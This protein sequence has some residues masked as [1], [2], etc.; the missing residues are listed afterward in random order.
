LLLTGEQIG[1]FVRDDFTKETKEIIAKRAGYFCSN[2]ECGKPTVGPAIG[3]DKAINEGVAAHITA[4][5][6]GGPRY[7]PSL[8]PTQRKHQSNGIW[9]CS[10]CG[11]RIDADDVHFTVEMLRKW[12]RAAELQALLALAAPRLTPGRRV[13][14]AA[15]DTFEAELE[16]LGLTAQEYFESITLPLISAARTD[17]AAFKNMQ[18]W[19]LHP[20]ALN[21]RI[22]DVGYKQAFNISGLAAAIETFNEIV[23]IAPPGTGKTTTL[24][25]LAE[26]ILSQDKSVAVFIPLSEWS[27]QAGSFLESIVR[28]PA[29]AGVQ[30]EHLVRLAHHGRLVLVLDGWN[31]L[32]AASRK[33][34]TGEIRSLQRDFPD[35]A[36]IVS[37]RR[38]ALDVPISGPVVEIDALTE[39]QQLEIAR[40]LRGTEGEAILDHAWRTPGV[41]DL[42]AIPLYISALLAY[43]K[44][45]SLPTTKEEVLRLFVDEHERKPE[46]AEA[47]RETLLGFHTNM[48]RAIAVKATT[49]ATTTISEKHA[50]AV[51]KQVEDQ[52]LADGQITTAPQPTKVLDALVSH[53]TLVHASAGAGALSFQHQQFQE[54]YA[55]FEVEKLMRSAAAGDQEARQELRANI[56]NIPA[57]EEAILFACERMSRADGTGLK[58]VAAAVLETIGIDPML[59][60]EMIYRSSA[61]VWDEVKGKIIDF[62]EIWHIPGKVDRAFRFMIGTGCGE[63]ASQIWPLISHPDDQVHLE[64]LRAG[65]RFRPSVLGDDIEGHIANLPEEVR[66]NV[67]SSFAYEGDM[68]GIEL[69]AKLAQADPSPEVQVSVI[70]GLWFRRANRLVIEVLRTAPDEVWQLLARKGFADEITDPAA[71]TRLWREWRCYIETQPDS[72]SKLRALLYSGPPRRDLGPEVRTLIEAADFQVRDKHADG[73]IYEAHKRYP[74]DVTSALIHRL[75]AGQE[76][77]F[78]TEDL[79]QA[80][81]IAIDEGPFVD[82]VVH[83]GELEKVA[84]AAVSIAGPKTIGSLIDSLIAIDTKLRASGRQADEPTRQEYYRLRDW[85]SKTNLTSFIQAVLSRSE[86]NDPCQ[87]V[88][89]AKLLTNHG[90]GEFEESIQLDGG[91]EDQM[92]AAISCWAE[93]LLA[94]STASRAHLAEVARAIGRL[95]AP[96]LLPLLQRMLAEDLVRWRRERDEFSAAISRGIHIQSEARS[97]WTLWYRRA[98]SAIGSDAVVGLMKAYLPDTDF[99]FDAACVLKAIWDQKHNPQKDKWPSP[100]PDFSEV[101]ARCLEREEHVSDIHSSPFADAIFAVIDHLT[102]PDSSPNDHLRALQLAKIAFSMP[103]GKKMATIE[104]LLKLP[105][106]RRAKSELLAVLVRSGEII[107]ADMVLDNLKNLIEEG[108]KNPW[109]LDERSREVEDWLVLMPFSDR[110]EATLDALELLGPNLRQPWQMHHLLSALGDSPSPAS[111]AVLKQ[112]PQKDSRFLSQYEWFTALDKRGTES[113]TRILLEFICEGAF[114][115]KAGGMDNWTLGRKLAGAM[116]TYPD[117]RAEV[118]QR[119]ECQPAGPVKDILGHTISE[120]A[121]ADGLLLLIRSYAEQGK[122]ASYLRSAIEHV[123]VGRR[124][125]ADW[126]GATET[127]S[128]PVSE[129]RKMLFSMTKD[130]TPE[131]R[132]AAGCLTIIDELRD[133]YGPAESEPRHPDIDSGRPW[134]LE[135]E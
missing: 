124:P 101:K 119:Y 95:A 26:A 76:I 123:A 112:L 104:T 66:K 71:I 114:D 24:L 41:R 22:S 18:G 47:L 93:V 133:E 23:V 57:W 11:R 2:P 130:D 51:V 1:T 96:D 120:A 116:Q 28:R 7:D 109:L 39:G 113:A 111:E 32:D 69:A 19:P 91:L 131:A 31:E 102:I 72:E 128:V 68:D 121:D 87:I 55:S 85:I 117:F 74:E 88:L 125:S 110:P 4:A 61:G 25:Q 135:A 118:Y 64:A 97:S 48:L 33:R 122:P 67:I 89:L 9:A 52:L 50:N 43:T 46:K 80:N 90:K 84:K 56:L 86:T 13:T 49:L 81:G 92:I 10:N 79:L 16:R 59:A 44:D 14:P 105:N 8:T 70:E 12:K 103:Y 127:F 40:S 3:H 115:K 132:L 106:Q 30:E 45:A 78:R 107:S 42:V 73:I 129:L 15:S 60:A 134:P 65:R 83:P 35:L 6:P 99:G 62:V 21:L 29:F 5:S 94:H 20:I 75:E 54:W 63:F 17:L 36:I 27:S 98:F 58:A 100:W 82:L 38:Q 37:T 108:K 53:H 126:E 34:A 77:P